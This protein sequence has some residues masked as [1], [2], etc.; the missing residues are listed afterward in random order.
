[1]SAD[2]SAVVVELPQMICEMRRQVDQV[3]TGSY[4]LAGD[5]LG[6]LAVDFERTT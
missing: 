5:Q 1:M 3:I 6:E 4:P 2:D